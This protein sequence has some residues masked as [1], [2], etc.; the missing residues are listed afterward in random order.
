MCVEGNYLHM[1]DHREHCVYVCVV[2]SVCL[3]VLHEDGGRLAVRLVTGGG[4][5]RVENRSC[6]A[7]VA[8]G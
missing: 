4:R 2:A 5:V 8:V 7:H 6:K 3:T 1:F